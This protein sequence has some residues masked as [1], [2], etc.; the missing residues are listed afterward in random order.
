M[1]NNKYKTPLSTIIKKDFAKNK[2]KYSMLIP[3]LL[4]YLIFFYK[5]MYGALIAFMDYQPMKGFTGSPWVGFKH[6]NEFF[7]SIYFNRIFINTFTLSFLDI[8]IGF[9]I[10]IILTILINEIQNKGYK[11]L[12][13]TTSYLPHFISIVVVCGMIKDYTATNGVI[14]DIIAMFGGTRFS[15]LQSAQSFK[16]VY[17]FSNI[18]QQAG[19]STIIFLSAITGINEELYEAAIIDGANRFNKIIHITLPGI[20]PTIVIMLILRIGQVLN[21]GFEKILLLYN[22]S[23]YESA[24]VIST[25]V[26]RK[27]LEEFNWSF[28]T[29][30]GLF[31][32]LVNFGFLLTANWI[33]KKKT[34]SGLW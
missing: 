25:F 13:Q 10:P 29:A 17:V 12:V 32:S 30:V 15:I 23:I 6:F 26:Y 7:S 24:D 34:D 16:F 14:N 28:S 2:V 9:P 8:I 31:N 5:P 4:F 19:W 22:P 33:S 20:L 11:K 3:V 1:F 27:G 18:W 21:V